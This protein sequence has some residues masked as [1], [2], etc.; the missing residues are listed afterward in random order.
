VAET[1]EEVVR[2]DGLDNIEIPDSITMTP[3]V[4]HH[5]ADATLREKVSSYLT[6]LG[7]NEIMTNS[8]T[9]EAYFD[10]VELTGAVKMLNSLSAQLNIMRPSMLETG[11]E[12]IAHN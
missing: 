6:G 3:S 7:F 1:V 11:V 12:S 5:Y 9:N 2:I 4:E 10:E 8:I